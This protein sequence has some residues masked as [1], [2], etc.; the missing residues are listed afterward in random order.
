MT[1]NASCHS[2]RPEEAMFIP[3]TPS[4]FI[5]YLYLI[6]ERGTVTTFTAAQPAESCSVSYLSATKVTEEITSLQKH[7]HDVPL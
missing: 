3:E 7:H 6:H 1:T 5:S 2:V 4:L